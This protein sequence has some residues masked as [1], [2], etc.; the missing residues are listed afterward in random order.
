M[1]RRGRRMPFGGTWLT[2]VSL[3]NFKGF[4]NSAQ[5]A[6]ISRI[7]LIYGPN[8]SGKSSIIQALLLLAQSEGNPDRGGVLEPQGEYVD[9][10][11]FRSL[12]HRHREK[13]EVEIGLR[14]IDSLWMRRPNASPEEVSIKLAFGRDDE[15][16][17]D[18]P[19][20]NRVEYE[21]TRDDATELAV[22]LN[23]APSVLS[24]EDSL[25]AHLNRGKAT[26][27]WADTA[28][29]ESFARYG[30]KLVAEGRHN[31]LFEE[32]WQGSH[33]ATLLAN[34]K[35]QPGQELLALLQSHTF[36]ARPSV[37]PSLD[38]QE[39][40]DLN[41]ALALPLLFDAGGFSRQYRRFL[42]GI[43][44]LGPTL[45]GPSRLYCGV[46][47][48]R[49]TVGRRGESTFD[50]L[51]HNGRAQERVNVCFQEFGI[52]YRIK[53]M[54]N[55]TKST[56]TGTLSTME[57]E[58]TRSGTIVTPVDVGYGI[59]QILPII[60]EGVAGRSNVV[61]VDQ[62]E[63]H[64]DANL[65]AGIADLM[66]RCRR[67]QWIVETHSEAIAHRLM[68]R[69]AEG[70]LA[71]SDVSVLYVDPPE[72]IDVDKGSSIWTLPIEENGSFSP[73][74]PW[75]AGRSPTLD[76]YATFN[77]RFSRN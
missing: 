26:F 43:S 53:D 74:I 61:C 4:G 1:R 36:S 76:T 22:R 27:E 18:L 23:R 46:G 24:P 54:P 5:S 45:D 9:L 72:A 44:Y 19:V 62:P 34:M 6:P 12:V 71:S 69:I 49:S 67:K 41:R 15:V 8:S 66:N 38:I 21:L 65:Q 37:V 16:Y 64:L 48:R 47:S 2:E 30:H 11:G 50:I 56:L 14:L 60:V 25:A 77:K 70:D 7:T 10:A 63:V 32:R 28:S 13:E 42:D 29:V 17:T 31:S 3:R 73:A 68:Q 51:C 40:P 59:S 75:P 55:V 52:P 58:D 39:H 35:S 20:L 33:I 57:L